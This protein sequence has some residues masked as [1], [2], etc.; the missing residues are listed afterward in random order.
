[1]ETSELESGVDAV[2]DVID[3]IE[4]YLEPQKQQLE[5]KDVFPLPIVSSN[6]TVVRV[7]T[8][9]FIRMKLSEIEGTII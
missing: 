6:K 3:V 7:L 4:Y 9:S 1:M 2:I 5:S 8:G